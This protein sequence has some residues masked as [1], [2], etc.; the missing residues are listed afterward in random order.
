MRNYFVKFKTVSQS[1][2]LFLCNRFFKVADACGLNK[3]INGYFY[4][5][6]ETVSYQ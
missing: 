2:F 4:S 5:N 6:F 3:M 1:Y